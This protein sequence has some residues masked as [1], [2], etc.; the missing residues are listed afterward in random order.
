MD[1]M[2]AF[3]RGEANRGK[4][5]MVFDWHKAATLINEMKPEHVSAGL[6]SDWEWTG[7][8]IYD[9]GKPL[10][11]DETYVY[12]ASTW[13]TPEIDLDGEIFDCYKMETKTDGWNSETFWP[14]SAL[15]MLNE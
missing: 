10:T 7:G 6:Q 14:Q 13:A 15:D 9:N 12:L 5:Q 2:S 8:P 3:V 11:Q 4:E 1:S